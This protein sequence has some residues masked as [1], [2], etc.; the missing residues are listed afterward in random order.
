MTTLTPAART[1]RPPR[2]GA[3]KRFFR[4]FR[5]VR[6]PWMLFLI[7]TGA[8]LAVV[9]VTIFA[10]SVKAKV[11]MGDI[12]GDNF[13]WLY[14][15]VIFIP[16]LVSTGA[17][18][19]MVF[20]GAKVQR[21][22]QGVAW[23]KLSSASIEDLEAFDK[24]EQ[25]SRVTNDTSGISQIPGEVINLVT[26]LYSIGAAVVAI[27]TG[28]NVTLALWFLTLIPLTLAVTWFRGWLSQLVGRRHQDAYGLATSYFANR[29]QRVRV[30]KPLGL[31]AEHEAEGTVPNDTLFRAEMWATLR[32]FVGSISN[33]TITTIAALI[34]YLVGAQLVRDGEMGVEGIA[35]G[36]EIAG[37][38][39]AA[40]MTSI[41]SYAEVKD[42]QGATE[43]LAVVLNLPD[44]QSAEGDA[45]PESPRDIHLRDVRLERGGCPVLHD[46]SLDF[47]AGSVTA[48]VGPRGSGKSTLLRVLDRSLAPTSGELL[49]DH[50]PAR[51]YSL[52]SWR[53]GTALV[54]QDSAMLS[55]TIADTIRFGD[56]EMGDEELREAAKTA[57]V[58]EFVDRHPDGYGRAIGPDGA[59]LSGGQRQRVAIARAVA[60]RPQYLLLDE[61]AS[62]LDAVTHERVAANLREVFDGRTVVMTSH[63]LETVRDADQIVVMNDGT[64]EAVGT[65]GDL[66]AASATYRSLVTAASTTHPTANQEGMRRD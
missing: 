53:E 2:K 36:V 37:V 15:A 50:E 63:H 39:T 6:F 24:R 62:A 45:I 3:W 49:L 52:D 8:S 32:T 9:P 11:R 17:A 13:V 60:T 35:L 14:V 30:L 65:H 1:A 25:V 38:L 34:V 27:A 40:I 56:L 41:S 46:V 55:G 20:M 64:V 26:G 19:A 23:R 29:L 44:E 66:L 54:P 7:G 21:S 47:P 33:S 57:A 43:K 22:A 18:I 28:Q 61:A 59:G 51:R 16:I 12:L 10:A 42:V 31:N 4:I 48:I 5:L 58:D